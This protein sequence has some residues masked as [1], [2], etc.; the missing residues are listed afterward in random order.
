MQHS[1]GRL[2]SKT[3]VL[4][5]SESEEHDPEVWIE[6]DSVEE[7]SETMAEV[8]WMPAVTPDGKVAGWAEGTVVVAVA[9]QA[10]QL[11][12]VD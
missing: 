8:S 7:G 4:A 10:E 2:G 1:S 3:K 11:L 9:P 5:E 6:N 12:G